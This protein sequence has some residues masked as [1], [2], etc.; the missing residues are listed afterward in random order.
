MPRTAGES[1]LHIS[2]V[3]AIIENTVPLLEEKSH[4]LTEVDHRIGQIIAP[5]ICDGATIQIGIG[6][7]PNAVAEHLVNHK[8]LGIHTEVVTS[9][10]IDL[11]KKVW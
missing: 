6:R 10:L 1:L 8:D 2:E 5:M 7:V 3:D 11:I 9:G 4:P